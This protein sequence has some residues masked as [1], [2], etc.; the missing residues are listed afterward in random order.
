M[1]K[2][3]FFFSGCRIGGQRIFAN[4]KTI[5]SRSFFISYRKTAGIVS[6]L[7]SLFILSF[8][9]LSAQAIFSEN[10]ESATRPP[11]FADYAFTSACDSWEGVI[12]TSPRTGMS[13]AWNTTPVDHTSGTGK[14]LMNGTGGGCTGAGSAWGTGTAAARGTI[15]VTTGVTYCFSVWVTNISV[16]STASNFSLRW[17][18]NGTTWTT[19][20]SATANNTSTTVNAWVNIRGFFTATANNVYLDVYNNTTATSGNDFG[21]DDISLIEPT[22]ISGN[23]FQDANGLSDNTVNGTGTNVSNGVYANL[24]NS[25]TNAVVSSAAV[26]ADGSYLFT[27][28]AGVSYNAILTTAS[29]TVGAILTTASLPA[30]WASTGENT[31]AG[32][33]SDGTANGILPLGVVMANTTNVNFGITQRPVAG[34]GSGNG[35]VALGTLQTAVP[36]NT[37]T[38]SSASTDA[39]GTISSISITAFP[40]NT[41]T[42]VINGTSYTSGTFP[43]AGITVPT[44]AS[45]NPTQTITV[46]PAPNT[47]TTITISFR[48]NDNAGI[49]STNTGTAVLNLTFDA[50]GDPSI[51]WGLGSTTGSIYPVTTGTVTVGT[52]INPAYT[53]NAISAPNSIGYNP[54]NGKFYYF[55][56]VG[57]PLEFISFDPATNNYQMLAA[58]LVS[59]VRGAVNV[60]G[61]GFYSLDATLSYYNIASNTWTAITG[62]FIDQ[63]GND[64]SSLLSTQGS[65]DIAFDGN[66]NLWLVT[67]SA[68]PYTVFKINAPLPTTAVAS[69]PVTRVAS[70]TIGTVTIGG[71]GFSTAGELFMQST[72]NLYK[73]NNDFTVTTVGAISSGNIQDLTSCAFPLS[74]FNAKD[75]GDAPDTYGTSIAANGPNHGALNYSSSGNTA[76]LMIGN[77]IDLEMD[78]QPGTTATGDDTNTMDDEGGITTFPLLYPTSTSYSL[79]VAVTNSNTTAATLS[80]WIDFNRNG[81]FDASERTQAAIAAGATSATLTWTGLSGLVSGQSYVRVRLATLASEV[82]NPTGAASDGEVEDYSITIQPTISGNVFN[83][84]NGLSDNTVNG[85]GTNAANNV[86]ANL[87]NAST[88]LVL[89]SVAVPAGG[90]YSFSVASGTSCN[91]ILTTTVQTVGAILT[92]A[93]VPAG[94]VS[95]GEKLGTGTGSDGTVNGILPLGVVNASVTDCNFGID[96]R[97]VAGSGSNTAVNP[98]GTTQVTVPA[99]TFTNTSASTDPDGTISS[100]TITAFPNNTT[101]VVINGTSYTSGTFPGAGVTVPTD[102]NGNPTQVITVDPTPVAGTSITISFRANDNAGITSVGTGAAVLNITYDPCSNASIIWG[103]NSVDGYIYP[104]NSGT[105]ATGTAINPAYTGLAVSVPNAIGYNP[106]NGRFYYIKRNTA[107]FEFFSFDPNTGNYQSLAAPPGASVRGAVNAAG[108]G[109]YATIAGSLYYYSIAANTWTLITSVFTDQNG[110]N[111][112]SV[113]ATQG[114]GDFAFDGNN[115]LWMVTSSAGPFTVF[116]VTA[117]LPVTA[118]ASLP[119]TTVATGTIAG[120]TIGG[121]GFSAAGELFMLS[122]TTLY[123]LNN[124]FTVSTVGALTGTFGDLTS[125]AFPLATFSAKDYGDAP[126][127]YGT[128]IAASGASHAPLGYNATANTSLLMLGS[129]ADLE[130]DGQPGVN[131]NGDD[132]NVMDDEA[133]ITAFPPLLITA[134][135]YSVT[136]AVTNSNTTAA[137]LSGW[138]DFNRNGTFDAGERAQATVAAAATSATLTWTGLSGLVAGQTYARFRIAT[139]A[140]EVANPTGAAADGEVEDYTLTIQNVISG[141][142]FSDADRNTIFG[143]GGTA[144]TGE[145]GA[146]NTGQLYAYLVSGTTIIDSAWVRTDGSYVLSNFPLNAGAATVVIGANSLAIGSVSSSVA[147]LSS[148]PPGGWVYSGSSSATTSNGNANSIGVTISTTPITDQNFGLIAVGYI[149]IHKKTLDETSSTDFTFN[150]S[151]GITTVP[152]FQLNDNPTQIPL[153]DIGSSQNGRLWAVSQAASTPASTLY[154]RNAGSTVWVNTGI[155]NVSRVD[156]GPANTCYFITNAGSVISYDGTTSTTIGAAANYG[157]SNASDIGSTWDYRPYITT[158]AGRIYR[159]SGAGTVWAQIGATTN[160]ARI[161]GNP[162]TGDIIV[163]KTDNNTYSITPAAVQTS[164]GRPSDATASNAVDV[165]VD[166][167]GNI[168]ATYVSSTFGVVYT[169]KWVSGTTWSSPELT[170]RAATNITGGLGEQMWALNR[171]NTEAPYGN[172]FSRSTGLNVN[173]TSIWWLDDERVRTAPTNGNSQMIAVIPGSYNLTETVPAGWDLQQITLY[174]PSSNSTSNVITN[175]ATLDVSAGEVVHAVVQNGIVNAF[176]MNSNCTIT[177]TGDFGTGSTGTFGAALTGQTSYHYKN[178]YGTSYGAGEGIYKIVSVS[179]DLFA[180]AV[181]IF[182]HT[183]GDGTGRMMAVDAGFSVDEFFR[184]RFTGLIPGAT[185]NFSA[186]IASVSNSTVK[187]N[188][189]FLS[190]DPITYNVLAT[191][192][193]GDITT[194][195]VWS[196]YTLSFT[197]TTTNIDLVLRNNTIGG[198]GNDLALD[199]ISLTILPVGTPVSMITDADC[200]ASNSGAITVTFPVGAFFEYSLDGTNYQSS[201]NFTGLTAGNYTVYARYVG[202]TGCAASKSETIKAAVC[203]IVYRDSNGLNGTPSN[204]VDGVPIN[205]GGLNVVLYDKTTG[206]VASVSAVSGTGTYTLEAIL[207][208]NFDVYLT[209]NTATVGQ[210]AIP[211]VAL[212]SNWV[213]TGEYFGS[214]AGSDASVNGILS[215]GIV[216]A[217]V[218]NVNF[219]I[220]ELPQS[221]ANVQAVNSPQVNQF[222]TLDGASGNPAYLTGSDPEDQPSSATL[223]AKTVAITALPDHGQLWYNGSQLTTLSTLANFNPSLLQFKATGTGYVST[224]FSFAYVDIAG[225]QDPTPAMYTLTWTTPLAISLTDFTVKQA[226]CNAIKINWR[227]NN[228]ISY[229]H[230]ELEKNKGNTDFELVAKINIDANRSFYNYTENNLPDGTYYYRLKIIGADGKFSYS[231][232]AMVSINCGGKF[233]SVYPNPFKERITVSGVNKGDIIQV[234]NPG[235][236]LIMKKTVIAA[237]E[238]LDLRQYVQGV[239]SLLITGEGGYFYSIKIVKTN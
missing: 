6:F 178:Y 11:F 147:N 90:T 50:C 103:L 215:I 15:A 208:H 136:V 28:T 148:N 122:Q 96:Q 195:G 171:G 140:A 73:L 99:N 119:M 97:P 58:P 151:G 207:G 211:T 64:V 31:G 78:G 164:L 17:S 37:F 184:R 149:Y 91:V 131:A 228:A 98:G 77:R 144:G 65:G 199:D 100:I 88:N 152:S 232:Q 41:T 18:T 169:Y 194:A 59:S 105:A 113:I 108:T 172:I 187:P 111:V 4:K 93:S 13:V 191:N 141:T 22:L 118:V 24:V 139:L 68:G 110:N 176:T 38:S 54:V 124:D 87:V 138:I 29:Q 67:S 44:D 56:R 20:T 236:Q 89:T 159:Y 85:S 117:P 182:D 185:Y 193:T 5:C 71:V 135:S 57:F 170:A 39:D 213:N 104:I 60:S 49:T 27:A 80:G 231:Q 102:A 9:N 107:T 229:N 61:T 2:P 202:S 142:V 109:F 92:A 145:N 12:S 134:G 154:Y 32:T 52:A 121:V 45:G 16:G 7:I 84:A 162:A 81:T 123:K 217:Q 205:S 63:N 126:D 47:G 233:V 120:I 188:V 95:T 83:D 101:T 157:G 156:G 25:T 189:S 192:S 222:I 203:G 75:Y 225:K 150:I 186:W 133:G 79:A 40:A 163:S 62:V 30:G 235:G 112:S 180:G 196:Q 1:K 153:A 168:Y 128:T 46:D 204:T 143:T 238:E 239:Y 14:Y 173:G 230:F 227:A 115:N 76:L 114:S 177:Y 23:I 43:G 35:L 74:V 82:A 166:A 8:A 86:Y 137:T 161:D 200:S 155:A 237:I 48:A 70:G 224:T 165:G 125:C 130:M 221:Y 175:S 206:Q 181:S 218:S 158:A 10:F 94:W 3:V 53:G 34:G 197:A 212:P 51:V 106:V 116:K 26:A 33:G 198:S 69:I 210:T 190:I 223:S 21:I 234:Y 179:T 66:G 226:A 72:T 216:N 129:T 19:M 127:T 201:T 174:D 214:G 42:M 183:S 209:T 55:K 219:G 160:N 132:T 36:G 220:E 167:V 146:T